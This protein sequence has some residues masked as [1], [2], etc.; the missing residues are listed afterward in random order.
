V[1]GNSQLASILGDAD[2]LSPAVPQDEEVVECGGPCACPKYRDNGPYYVVI[3]VKTGEEV[4]DKTEIKESPSAKL[5][6]MQ[7][8]TT[9]CMDEADKQCWERAG[10]DCNCDY[11]GGFLEVSH[12]EHT[13]SSFLK[14]KR[15][16]PKCTNAPE[17][18]YDSNG[19]IHVY[20]F[21]IP[22]TAEWFCEE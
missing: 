5:T 4:P 14:Y 1:V 16:N 2:S 17:K 22:E 3:F 9:N 15:K 13:Q 12:T 10:K 18:S 7:V 11:P 8:H 6:A 20:K 21:T 19:R